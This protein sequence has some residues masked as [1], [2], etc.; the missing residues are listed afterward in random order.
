MNNN[1][2]LAAFGTFGNPYGF[3]QTFFL[4]NIK[5]PNDVKSFDLNTVAIKLFPNSRMYAIRKEISNSNKLV[6]Y[7]VYDFANEPNSTRGGTF[8]GS[9]ILFIDKISEESITTSCLIDFQENLVKNNVDNDEIKV[10][11]SNKLLNV[12]KPIDFDKLEFNLKEVEDLSFTQFS[13]KSLVVYC[14]TS[15][16]KLQQLLKDALDLLNIY[17][18]IYFTESREVAEFVNQKGIFK[19]IQNVGDKKDF[20][21]EISNLQEERKRKRDLSILE[22]EKEI[23]KLED[24]KNRLLNDFK[25]Q[26]EQSEKQHQE[27]NRKI[28]EAKNNLETVKQ[29]YNDFS[30]KIK[31]SI[32]QLESSGKLDE[33][34]QLYNENKRRFIEGVHHLQKPIFINHIN[35]PKAKSELR[36][37]EQL[38]ENYE[39]KA[40][41]KQR[42]KSEGSYKT[43]I[44][45]VVLFGLVVLLIVAVGIMSYYLFH[46]IKRK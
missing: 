29:F 44:F 35:K 20:E 45:K 24:D 21:Q 13:G 12:I 36:V 27:N 10:N 26:I 7:S 43:D 9:S 4:G 2:I 23:Q 11:H 33:V 5:N 8:I 15:S 25:T 41:H 6:S 14:K 40:L 1:V 18:V 19:L 22:F 30:F 31:D 32:N 17:D 34:K 46:Y 16:D 37:V 42:S 3:R 38:S 39:M 28:Q